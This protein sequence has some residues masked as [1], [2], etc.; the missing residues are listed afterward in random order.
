[1]VA[2]KTRTTQTEDAITRVERAREQR[3]SFDDT[4]GEPNE[5]EFARSHDAGMLGHLATDE[6]TSRFA[7]AARNAADD[8]VDV[9][10]NELAD[11]DVVEKEQW[12]RAVR[13]NVID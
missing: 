8:V 12:L 7:T 10:G 5:V 13:G 1:A 2:P 6:R 11:R 3:G 9:L 4:N